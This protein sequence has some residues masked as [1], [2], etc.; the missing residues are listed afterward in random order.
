M[1]RVLFE[2]YGFYEPDR[3]FPIRGYHVK[4]VHPEPQGWEYDGIP[5]RFEGHTVVNLQEYRHHNGRFVYTG[6][7]P[8][9]GKVYYKEG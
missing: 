1:I 2:I 6:Q 3:V 4:C 5:R 8:V 9:C 7:C